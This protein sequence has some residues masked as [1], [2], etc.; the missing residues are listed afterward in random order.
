ML[1]IYHGHIELLSKYTGCQLRESQE[2]GVQTMMSGRTWVA[3]LVKR[4]TSA[5]VMISQFTGSSP[6]SGSLLTAQSLEPP[7]DPVSPSLA[8]LPQSHSVSLSK[9]NKDEKRIVLKN[10]DVR[11]AALPDPNDR[12]Y[13]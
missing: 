10:Y 3:Q 12:N 7:S 2:N 4:P 8:A 13:N 9:M 6:A 5:Q 11:E 1:S